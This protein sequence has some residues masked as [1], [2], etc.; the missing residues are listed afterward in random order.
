MSETRDTRVSHLKRLARAGF[1]RVESFFDTVFTPAWNP[2]YHLGALGWFFYWIVAVSGIY[3]YAF[4]DSG[5]TQAYESVEHITHVQWYAGGVMR[6]LHRYASDALVVVMVLH[7]V[8]EFVMDRLHG[9]RWFAWVIGVPMIWL[10]FA[11]GISGY[12]VVW[13]KLGQYVAIATSQ[14]LDALP[15]FG[16]PIAR[17]FIH[18]ST[19]S[20][21]FFTLMV[22]IHIAVPLVLLFVMWIH[23]HRHAHANVNPPRGLAVGML[24][25]LVV[26]SF[27]RPALSQ[28][29]ANLDTVPA[30]VGLDWFYL[31]LYPLL[32]EYS[33]IAMWA[34]LGA[35]S[36]L[37]LALPWLPRKTA[38]AAVVDLDNCNGCERCAIDCPHGAV[39]MAVRSDGSAYL[40]EAV[41]DPAL[42]VACGICVGACPTA[43][44]FRR[45]S[46]LKAGIELPEHPLTELREQSLTRCRDLVG[47]DRVMVYGCG[48]GADLDIIAGASVAVIELPCIAMLAPAFIDF[49]IT[50]HHVDG[51]FL[52][53]CRAGDCYERLGARWI[54]QRMAGE[55]DP[56]LRQRV[57]R[58][59][60]A[61]FWAGV[62]GGAALAEELAAFRARLRALHTAQAPVVMREREAVGHAD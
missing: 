20:G 13:D 46:A 37:L 11:A 53:G 54:E 10:V 55:R 51:V 42:C 27:V 18:E 1:E 58:E 4:F 50:R 41:V 24:T 21:R 47:N 49:M 48:H 40:Q 61:T 33:G 12:W 17:N 56:Y 7:L 30:V 23:I 8:R 3:L 38:V 14:W 59:R 2:F 45:R 19:L 5:V 6:S 9:P 29:P 57:P 28:G 43:T 60:I 36:L 52:T 32:D 34:L 22:F 26:L 35:A 25:A 39:R 15:L 44:P 31:F 16:E 62:D